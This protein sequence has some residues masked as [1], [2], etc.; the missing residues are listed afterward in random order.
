MRKGMIRCTVCHSIVPSGLRCPACDE[1]LAAQQP[2]GGEAAQ[3]DVLDDVVLAAEARRRGTLHDVADQD[4]GTGHSSLQEDVRL[5]LAHLPE[6]VQL[7]EQVLHMAVANFSG[8]KGLLA[9]TDHRLLFICVEPAGYRVDTFRFEQLDA[10]VASGD[11][12]RGI[13]K[14]AAFGAEIQITG[15]RPAEHTHDFAAFVQ[16]RIDACVAYRGAA[17]TATE[18]RLGA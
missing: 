10:I 1:P 3:D 11:E 9:L 7:A 4:L 17:R 18:Q 8:H 14:M 16:D 6:H 15:I 12:D 13:L 5:E 2:D